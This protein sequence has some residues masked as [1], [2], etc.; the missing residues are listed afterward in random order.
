MGS[1]WLSAMSMSIYE[2][3]NS[4]NYLEIGIGNDFYTIFNSV[5]TSVIP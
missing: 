3:P 2:P 1:R 5:T 4:G